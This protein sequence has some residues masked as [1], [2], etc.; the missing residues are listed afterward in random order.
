MTTFSSFPH[1]IIHNTESLQAAADDLLRD[2][3][4]ASSTV[5]KPRMTPHPHGVRW[6][7]TACDAA[8]N[9]V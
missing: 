3:D 5:F 4:A 2:I 9:R 8:L 6:W 1:P 7:N